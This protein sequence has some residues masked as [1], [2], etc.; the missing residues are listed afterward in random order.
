MDKKA[1][2]ILGAVAGLATIGAAHAGEPVSQPSQ[3]LHASSYADLWSPFRMPSHVLKADDEARAHVTQVDGFY[4]SYGYRQPYYYVL[5]RI[6]TDIPMSLMDT[7][8]GRDTIITTTIITTITTGGIGDELAAIHAVPK[9]PRVRTWT[10][11]F[12][13][14]RP[15]TLLHNATPRMV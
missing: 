4:F 2:G 15:W 7:M 13:R 1:A 10:A 8:K 14:P 3:P 12:H 5:G 6:H 9:A 11:G